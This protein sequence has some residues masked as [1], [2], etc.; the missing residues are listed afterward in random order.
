MCPS[1]PVELY[2]LLLAYLEEVLHCECSLLY[3]SRAGGPL[4]DR[5]DPFQADLVDLGE[6][7][8]PPAPLFGSCHHRQGRAAALRDLP[9][10]GLNAT[11]D[12]VVKNFRPESN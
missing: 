11:L 12:A 6:L 5:A 10:C 2:E 8:A 7:T 1:H 9:P 3:E 4:P